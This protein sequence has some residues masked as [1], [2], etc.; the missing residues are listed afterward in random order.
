M[1]K[2][3]V[4]FPVTVAVQLLLEELVGVSGTGVITTW[5]AANHGARAKFRVRV[6]HLRRI[7]RAEWNKKQFRYLGNGLA[8]IKWKHSDKEFRTVG[9][10]RSG[11]F[12][13]L[14][15]CTHKQGVYNPHDWLNTAKR[16]KGEVENGQWETIE[17]EP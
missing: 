2:D 1:A 15:G 14:L 9:F 6:H 10:F 16:R 13:M 4:Q 11:F 5:L 3:V 17:H 12:L 7:P 8:E